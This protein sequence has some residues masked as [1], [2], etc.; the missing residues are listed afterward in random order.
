MLVGLTWRPEGGHRGQQQITDAVTVH[1]SATPETRHA[2][3][4]ELRKGPITALQISIPSTASIE[5]FQE[6]P[7]L[8][9]VN[10][11]KKGS[12]CIMPKSASSKPFLKSISNMVGLRFIR[13]CFKSGV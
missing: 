2:D 7:Q 9:A 13:L 5:W 3:G 1:A 10:F 4:A 6:E 11:N 8:E 12:S